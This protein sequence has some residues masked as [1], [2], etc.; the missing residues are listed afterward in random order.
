MDAIMV[1]GKKTAF[2]Y[3]KYLMGEFVLWLIFIP[4]T[5]ASL[6]SL[7]RDAHIS[8][9][10]PIVHSTDQRIGTTFPP[11]TPS[12]HHPS[13]ACTCRPR[14]RTMAGLEVGP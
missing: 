3:I 8:S 11:S 1:G 4:S 10:S 6:S 9:Y 12:K 5:H 7:S 2:N 13:S 14:S